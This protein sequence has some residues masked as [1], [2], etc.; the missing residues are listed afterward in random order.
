MP[1]AICFRTE[2]LHSVHSA[3]PALDPEA[4]GTEAFPEC[5]AAAVS[6][7]PFFAGLGDAGRG[8]YG[9]NNSEAHSP[10]SPLL[11]S[12]SNHSIETVAPFRINAKPCPLFPARHSRFGSSSLDFLRGSPGFPLNE[13]FA[14]QRGRVPYSAVSC[15]ALHSLHPV[16]IHFKTS[17]DVR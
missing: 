6:L 14:P 12:C 15:V 13:S 17:V 1:T 9:A 10:S 3:S 7:R 5:Y 8:K 16:S 11:R 4:R 2:D